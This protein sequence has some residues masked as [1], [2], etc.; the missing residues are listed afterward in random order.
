MSRPILCDC[1]G[2]KIPRTDEIR[3]ILKP[4]ALRVVI[5]ENLFG[6]GI[7]DTEDKEYELCAKCSKKLKE[8]M[9]RETETL[10]ETFE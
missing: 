10:N 5:L 7:F 2:A 3:A 4:R 1:C 9:A 8:F 6:S